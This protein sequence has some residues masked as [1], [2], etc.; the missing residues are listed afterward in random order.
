MDNF[1]KDIQTI[2]HTRQTAST[3][4]RHCRKT[5]STRSCYDP[6]CTGHMAK[7][8][9]TETQK[10]ELDKCMKYTKGVIK[11]LRCWPKHGD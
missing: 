1:D 4:W 9:S 8:D 3:S 5:I 2:E 11:Q 7:V 6:Q 10:K